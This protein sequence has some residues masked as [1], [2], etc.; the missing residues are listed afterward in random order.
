MKFFIIFL[1]LFS[2]S[3]QGQNETLSTDYWLKRVKHFK[4]SDKDSTHYCLMKA[5][6]SI[7]NLCDSLKVDTGE[8]ERDYYDRKYTI[9]LKKGVKTLLEIN[10]KKLQLDSCYFRVKSSVLRRLFYTE[11]KIG[12][13][14]NALKYLDE[15]EKLY[16]FFS[17]DNRSILLQKGEIYKI[18]HHFD[19]GLTSLYQYLKKNNLSN[20]DISNANTLIAGIF[21]ERVIRNNES[22]KLLDSA[23]YHYKK[24][25]NFA[26]K[27]PYKQDFTTSLYYW[28]IADLEFH[29]KNYKKALFYYK[30][31]RESGSKN[32]DDYQNQIAYY[33]LG[34]CYFYLNRG[35]SAIYYLQKVLNNYPKIKT[36]NSVLHNTYN[37]LSKQYEKLQQTKKAYKYLKLKELLYIKNSNEKFNTSKVYSDQVILKNN[38]T[39]QK[40]V[41]KE[42]N[43]FIIYIFS[44]ITIVILF[45]IRHRLLKTKLKHRY[46]KLMLKLD[47]KDNITK[48]N[49]KNNT[50]KIKN[51]I[52]KKILLGLEN[53]EKNKTFLNSSFSI[54]FISKK[55]NVN[56]SY[57]S[58]TINLHKKMSFKEYLNNLRI[59]YIC[60]ALKENTTLQHYSIDALAKEI[61]YSGAS[62]FIKIFKSKTG[63]TPYYFIK[64][65]SSINKKS[66]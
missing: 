37:L 21:K 28:K 13:F 32:L 54:S 23:E 26:I 22:S 65:L 52:T 4:G 2:Y 45:L 5:K 34:N 41:L 33:S 57:V 12:N 48:L 18:I 29:R 60:L 31:S 42:K 17:K 59:D 53:L 16:T 9:V 24:A 11:K 63:V 8:L 51:D 66:T 62:S 43:K 64:N 1:A 6:E 46:E 50:V 36:S 19:K 38:A 47:Q 7:S 3:L 20:K 14:E 55:L 27:I 58:K 49:K 56:S 40:N 44:F 35:D 30:K 10:I 15:S 61:G 39:N 25:F